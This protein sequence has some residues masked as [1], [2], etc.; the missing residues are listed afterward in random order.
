MPLD[1]SPVKTRSTT[2]GDKNKIAKM[3]GQLPLSDS[4]K[5][6]ADDMQSSIQA[7]V[8]SALA[9]VNVISNLVDLVASKV[10]QSVNEN[11]QASL[12]QALSD[13]R[14]I[15]EVINSLSDDYKSHKEFCL[16]RLD[17]LEQY[18]RRNNLRVFGVV[19]KKGENTD[20]LLIDIFKNKLNV[21]VSLSD[22]DRSHRVGAVQQPGPDGKI[23]HRPIIVKF[24][25]YRVRRLVFENKKKLK[26][27]SVSVQEDLTAL[28]AKL[29]QDVGKVYGPKNTWTLDGRINWIDGNNKRGR[30]TWAF[31][32]TQSS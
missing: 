18:Q 32:H 14:C 22:I 1:H 19:E 6:Q 15:N 24:V 28:R 27:S 7:A 5:G 31:E 10:S 16:Q 13:I 3:P 23:K 2:V 17:D 30:T 21:D 29:L 26:G 8:E 9:N 20:T 11:I 25:S 4:A 12:Q